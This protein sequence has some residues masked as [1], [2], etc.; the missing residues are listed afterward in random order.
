LHCRSS[1][2]QSMLQT[3]KRKV[4]DHA[5]IFTSSSEEEWTETRKPGGTLIGITGPL[6]GR[7]K[8][9]SADK[10]GRWTQV[11]LLGQSGRIVSIICAY[12]VVQEVGRHGEQTAYSQ[13]VRMM[14][15]DGQLK[16]DP[17]RQFIVD[18]KALV[19]EL[20]EKGNDI[21]LMGEFK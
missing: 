10:Y 6:V 7:V 14:R 20:H 5:K 4:W 13:Q 2:V 12:Q 9:H 16:P 21:I 8:T 3:C 19:K 1:A 18:M 17:R 11:D 15:L